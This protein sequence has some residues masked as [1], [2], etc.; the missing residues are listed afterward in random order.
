LRLHAAA[1]YLVRVLAASGEVAWA[2]L[3]REL[4]LDA[5]RA[6]LVA[7]YAQATSAPAGE[8]L[9]GVSA[10]VYRLQPKVRLM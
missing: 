4:G 7:A 3:A 9:A 10:L 8:R 6:E 1:L 2:R 5:T